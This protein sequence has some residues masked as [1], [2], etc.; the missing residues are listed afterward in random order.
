MTEEQ[1]LFAAFI[2]DLGKLLERSKSLG[3]PKRLLPLMF[4]DMLSILH[5]W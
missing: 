5:N 1:F 4:T 3:F 2:H